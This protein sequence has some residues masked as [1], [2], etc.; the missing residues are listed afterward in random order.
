VLP[1]LGRVYRTGDLAQRLPD[2]RLVCLGRIDAQVKVRGHRIELE[3]VEAALAQCDGVREAA[4][5]VQDV[6]GVPLLAAFL[7]ADDPAAPPPV[8]AV[9]RRLRAALPESMVPA[10]LQFVPRCRAPSAASSTA[11]RCPTRR[12]QGP[13]GPRPT[14]PRRR[15]ASACTPGS[16]A[17]SPAASATPRSATTTTSSR[18]AATRCARRS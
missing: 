13:A 18:S 16:R 2:G 7:V 6:G 14:A 5:R 10:R 1:R 17:R 8:S 15:T 4:C 11:A 9:E 3:A 12:R